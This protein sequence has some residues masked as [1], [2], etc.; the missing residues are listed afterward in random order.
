MFHPNNETRNEKHMSSK[1]ITIANDYLPADAN[2]LELWNEIMGEDEVEF[3][4]V[5]TPSAGGT[6]WEIDGEDPTKEIKGVVI[7]SFV[8]HACYLQEYTGESNP[9][10]AYW[11]A[12]ELQH[13]SD[14]AKAIGLTPQSHLQR[15]EKISNRLV[16]YIARPGSLIPLRIDLS[17][18]SVRPW[19][20]FKQNQLASKGLRVTDVAV[21]LSLEAKKYASGFT[22]SFLRPVL[23]TQLPADAA[24]GYKL[25]G[26]QIKPFTRVRH[27]TGSGD[28]FHGKEDA[29]EAE[30]VSSTPEFDAAFDA[31]E[32]V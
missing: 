32:V 6:T 20:L 14:A 7:D 25:Q 10:D 2:T 19:R 27:I 5:T 3:P 8:A 17:G 24:A 23:L 28:S 31:T 9:P 18:A 21:S 22:G 13:L 1:E 29:L 12:G 26:E 4:T 11:I 30:E 16:L 15:H